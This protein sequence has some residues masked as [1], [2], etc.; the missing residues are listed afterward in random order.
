MILSQCKR[1]KV[2]KL[3]G[4]ID[5]EGICTDCRKREVKQPQEPEQTPSEAPQKACANCGLVL[6]LS[7]YNADKRT[8]DGLRKIC[9][10]C[11]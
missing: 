10:D 7:H 6:P 8:K 5:S 1:C 3:K 2:Y 4:Q 9:V 11:E